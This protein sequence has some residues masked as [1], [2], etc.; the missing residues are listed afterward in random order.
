MIDP[1][2]TPDAWLYGLPGQYL[3]WPGEFVFGYPKAGAD[4]L[5]PGQVNLPGPAWS[6]NGSYVVFRRL[7]QDVAGFWK[8]VHDYAAGL[9]K[10]PGFEGIT[11]D[12]LAARVLGRWPSGAPVSRVPAPTTRRSASTASRT[13]TSGS[14]RPPRRCRSPAA[15]KSNDWPEAPAD[16]VGLTCPMSAHIR[17]VN[18]RETPGDFGGRRA[19]FNR[20]ILRRGLPYGERLEKPLARIPS[21]ATGAFCSSATKPPSR[22]SSSSSAT[23]GW[24]ALRTRAARAATT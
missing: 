18:A 23:T 10:R 8:F 15:S 1:S 6:R 3:V 7:R 14:P 20:R 2:Y 4:P 17:K 16:P 9:N 5:L 24:A 19:S 13:T 11:E 12:W 22:I 21:T